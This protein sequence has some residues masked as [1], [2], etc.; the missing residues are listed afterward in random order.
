MNC[1][2]N[3]YFDEPCVRCAKF[4][5]KF[6]IDACCMDCAKACDLCKEISKIE[7]KRW[8]AEKKRQALVMYNTYHNI[9]T[10]VHSYAVTF[11]ST[12]KTP[13]AL[14]NA[15]AKVK[16]SKLITIVDY[17]WELTKDDFPHVHFLLNSKRYLKVRDLSKFNNGDNVNV[18]KLKTKT[19][20]AKWKN[21]INKE[22]KFKEKEYYILYNICLTKTEEEKL[23]SKSP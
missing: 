2:Y 7:S 6:Y 9:Q 4:T 23:D 10:E 5:D 16:K 15:F 19:D 17:C 3:R 21:Y 8:K 12:T 14:Q 13:F 11:T 1:S 22:K 18:Q 20:S